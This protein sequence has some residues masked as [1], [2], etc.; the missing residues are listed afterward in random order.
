MSEIRQALLKLEQSV[1]KLEG[2]VVHFEGALAG[3]QRDMFK[4]PKKKT[5][6]G[7]RFKAHFLPK[8]LIRLS[9]KLKPFSVKVE[10][11]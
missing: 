1:G 7:T 2:S 8:G 5:E 4:A 10:Y 11:G 3:Q 6:T 9:N